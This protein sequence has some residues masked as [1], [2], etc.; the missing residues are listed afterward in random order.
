MG[1]HPIIIICTSNGEMPW[2]IAY[3]ARHNPITNNV[4]SKAVL[5]N[6][7]GGRDHCLLSEMD[8]A[9]WNKL[10]AVHFMCMACPSIFASLRAD[11][12]HRPW[13][14]GGKLSC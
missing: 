8:L 7:H 2:Q 12:C 4:H 1:I 9:P 6:A 3:L 5:L 10:G 14:I 11:D 13:H